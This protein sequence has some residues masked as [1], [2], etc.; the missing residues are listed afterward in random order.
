MAT[1]RT[2]ANLVG[3]QEGVKGSLHYTVS[4]PS[5]RYVSSYIVRVSAHLQSLYCHYQRFNYHLPTVRPKSRCKLLM[6]KIALIS[7]ETTRRPHEILLH[8]YTNKNVYGSTILAVS[9]TKPSHETIALLHR[10]GR[11]RDRHL[12]P[13][14][15][16]DKTV[17]GARCH[18]PRQH[19]EQMLMYSHLYSTK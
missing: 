9:T 7:S 8:S 14:C 16:P 3:A 13:V 11:R 4:C 15:K 12:D 18:I 5:L 1:I 6:H 17:V 2:G 10:T 19:D